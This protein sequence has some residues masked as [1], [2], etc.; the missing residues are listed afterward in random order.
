MAISNDKL[1]YLLYIL[2]TTNYID[3]KKFLTIV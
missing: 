1:T 3:N 2:D